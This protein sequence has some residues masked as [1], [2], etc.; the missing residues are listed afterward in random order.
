MSLSYEPLWELLRSMNVPKMEFAKI[1]G[2]SNAT[3]AKLGKNEPVTL[4]IIDKICNEFDCKIEDVVQHIPDILLDQQE[5]D[6]PL[7]VGSIVQ[8]NYPLNSISEISKS[9]IQTQ[10]CVILEIKETIIN[11]IKTFQ[12]TTA[13]ISDVPTH[14][15]TIYFDNILINGKLS[16]GWISLNELQSMPSKYF[17]KIIGKMPEKVIQKI[18]RFLDSVKELLAESEL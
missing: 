17:V 4:T 14:Y 12:Y 18:D 7:N 15:L 1:I 2:I 11:K 10:T 13:P 16:H 3:L 6:L 5:S 9:S 8:T